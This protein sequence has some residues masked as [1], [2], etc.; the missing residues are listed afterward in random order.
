[1]A[2]ERDLRNNCVG[3]LK[4][5]GNLDKKNRSNLKKLS[6]PEISV[7]EDDGIVCTVC[8]STDGNPTDPIVL[9][10][11]SDLMVH[12][13][14]YGHPLT[15]GIPDGDWFC[16]QC[17]ESNSQISCCLC[18]VSGGALKPTTDGRWAYLVCAIYV[19]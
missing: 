2:T 6:D 8:E 9:C 1:M 3:I 12:A 5:T 14:C 19:P 15:T 17:I 4:L 11:G 16:A 18:P 7:N 10:D 13:S